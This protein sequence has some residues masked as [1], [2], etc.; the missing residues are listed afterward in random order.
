MKGEAHRLG[1]L[2][3]VDAEDISV[4]VGDRRA[5]VTVDIHNGMVALR[6][7]VKKALSC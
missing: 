1:K 6:I 3:S 4:S 5:A 7:V 2:V